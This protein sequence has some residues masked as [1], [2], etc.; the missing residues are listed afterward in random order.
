MELHTVIFYPK[1]QNVIYGEELQASVG[2]M[3]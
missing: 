2:I 3:K 1:I